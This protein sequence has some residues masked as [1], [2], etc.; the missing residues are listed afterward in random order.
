MKDTRSDQDEPVTED[1]DFEAVWR[2]L[3]IQF[4]EPENF[5]IKEVFDASVERQVEEGHELNEPCVEARELLDQWNIDNDHDYYPVWQAAVDHHQPVKKFNDADMIGT[6]CPEFDEILNQPATLMLGKLY[7]AKDRRN[8]QDGDWHTQTMPWKHWII[9][10][11]K[12]GSKP[13][14]GFSRHPEG[15]YKEGDSI[16]LGSGIDGARTKN[17]MKTMYALGLDI[18]SGPR[19]ADVIA[20]IEELGLFCLAY[21]SFNHKKTG[22]KLKR[23]EVLRK[24]KIDTDPDIHQIR[25]YLR[26]FDKNR[27]EE[28][29]IAE[30]AIEDHKKQE[31][32][33]VKIIL[34]SPPLEKFRLI[35]PFAE[36]VEIADL[37]RT[38]QAGLEIWEN[39]VTGMAVEV[40]GIHFDTSATDP[41]RL[42]YTPR[43]AK[44][45]ENFYSAIIQGQPLNFDDIPEY[46][47][48]LYT[49][50]REKLN[51]FEMAGG[52]DSQAVRDIP[53]T[54]EGNNLKQRWHDI[55]DRLLLANLLEDHCPDKIRGNPADGRVEIECPFEHE[56]S[57]EGGTA[58]MATNC[59]DHPSGGDTFFWKCRHD[60]CQGRSKLDFLSQALHDGWFEEELIF[61]EDSAYLLPPEDDPAD[62]GQDCC[63]S[64]FEPASDWLPRG[65][66]IRNETIYLKGEEGDISLCQRFDVV[67]RAST[68]S[69]D[70]GA[71]R[72]IHFQN[73]NGVEVETTL[74]MADLIRDGGGGVLEALA[75]AG[76]SL[77][78]GSKSNRDAI[79]NLFRQIT[80]QRHIPTVPRPG[81]V[82]DRGG[83]LVGFLCP[84]GEYIPASAGMPYRLSSA[85]T[86]KDRQA[87]GT[88]DSWEDGINVAFDDIG[89][90]PPNFFWVVGLAGAFAGP[91]LALADMD[92]CGFNLSGDSS[93]GKSLALMMGTSAWTTPRDK[94]GVFFSLSGTS[95]AV[96][97]LAA[98]G[99]E[100]FLALDEI[101][102]MQRPEDLA[103]LLF[104]LSSGSGKSRM[105]G[106]NVSAGLAEEAEFKVFAMMSN[107][108]SLR[109]VIKGAKADY[110]TGI[111]ARFPDLDVT[112]GARVSAE[113]IRRMEAVTANFGHAGPE[114]V[115]WLIDND[116]HKRGHVLRAMIDK[117]AKTLA[118]DDANPAQSRAAKVFALVRVAGKLAH[119]AGLLPDADKVT[120]AVRTAW[121]TFKTSDEGKATE[122]E[123]SLLD[124]FKSWLALNMGSK[125][126]LAS[127]WADG[128]RAGVVGWYTDDM[129]IL[130]WHAIENVAVLGLSG[131]RTGLV[132]ALKES[133]ALIPSGKNNN[134]KKLPVEVGGGEATNI[135]VDRAELGF[136]AQAKS[137]FER[138]GGGR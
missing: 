134:H 44:G 131:T 11:E 78:A 8:T 97:L 79:L 110:K 100:S 102:R 36:S 42:F 95:N 25:Q 118:G 72:I 55:K 57:S 19:L 54:P 127:E 1:A 115:R 26:E 71:G 3:D 66:R 108:R 68:I 85:A 89:D 106:R 2:D 14:W 135:R 136:P 40:L 77:Y 86:V 52:G 24:L 107:E 101:G 6:S 105:G 7:G 17:A 15:K 125:I 116:W 10:Q 45:S 29:F 112:A 73:E 75:D 130:D 67:G 23:D 20:K 53:L 126:I 43:H 117:A 70:A 92:G 114:F 103:P 121:D 74:H 12:T 111:S 119:R 124:G 87:L 132:A 50:K 41:S 56:H 76:M 46:K 122:G 129:I 31:K 37:G 123:S 47:K 59:T 109:T 28:S 99:S 69:G 63:S 38:H 65:Y 27:Y 90:R 21:S 49:S 138:A 128:N 18:D 51:A 88:L 30:I 62:A 13:A 104:G 81:W 32:D 94:K 61:D 48:S 113:T 98:I 137:A 133:G 39:K 64:E 83:A 9:G 58:C 82:R 4:N 16:V 91:L 84:T 5:S 96:E 33:G 93:R 60:A 22:L 35:F 34:S 120:A 80:P